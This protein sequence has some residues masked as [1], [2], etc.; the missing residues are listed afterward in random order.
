MA[1]SVEVMS[2]HHL[3]PSYSVA[4]STHRTSLS[5]LQCS[6]TWPARRSICMNRQKKPKISWK[7]GV[8]SMV[9]N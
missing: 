2:H 6:P 1:Y 9:E 8:C 7:S 5:V 3:T 4:A